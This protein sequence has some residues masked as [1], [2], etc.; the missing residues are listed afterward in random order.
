MREAPHRK[1][2]PGVR[3]CGMT[4]KSQCLHLLFCSSVAAVICCGC[5]HESVTGSY[6][7]LPTR[8]ANDASGSAYVATVTSPDG[9]MATMTS[10]GE[11]NDLNRK[12]YMMLTSHPELVPYPSKVVAVV[13]KDAGHTVVLSGTVP[14]NDVKRKLVD[15]VRHVHGVAEVKETDLAVKIPRNSREFNAANVSNR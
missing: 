1:N 7:P 11:A 5:A 4:T 15:A 2:P 3:I 9:G 10:S 8:Q 13:S 12:V 6:D 14:S